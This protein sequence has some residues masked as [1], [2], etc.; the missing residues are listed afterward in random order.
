MPHSKES[1]NRTMVI[2]QER[3]GFNGGTRLARWRFAFL[4]YRGDLVNNLLLSQDPS[5]LS[6]FAIRTSSMTYINKTTGH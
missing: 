4:E 2:N 3:N 1:N 5:V 6:M